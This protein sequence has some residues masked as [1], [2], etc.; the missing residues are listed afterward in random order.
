M[1]EWIKVKR[2]KEAELAY[3]LK[4]GWSA[5][6]LSGFWPLSKRIALHKAGI[7]SIESGHRI[8]LYKQTA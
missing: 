1:K 7:A 2:L 6:Y 4:C 8:E 3:C 5:H